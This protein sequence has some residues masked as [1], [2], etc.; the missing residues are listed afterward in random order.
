MAKL[1][2]LAERVGCGDGRALL[3]H[4]LGALLYPPGTPEPVRGGAAWGAASAA[5]RKRTAAGKFS[6]APPGG[7]AAATFA[8]PTAVAV[9]AADISGSP[10]EVAS[11]AG[12][13]PAAASALPDEPKAASAAP[14]PLSSATNNDDTA[15]PATGAGA[16]AL[17]V[18][19]GSAGSDSSSASDPLAVATGADI[20]DA[21]PAQVAAVAAAAAA[22]ATTAASVPFH[23]NA[24]HHAPSASP[25]TR[26][27]Q[28]I[29]AATRP[30]AKALEPPHP[31]GDGGNDRPEL[32]S[33][34]GRRVPCVAPILGASG[35]W[36]SV[37]AS[38]DGSTVIAVGRRSS[39]ID[40][41][42]FTWHAYC[43]STVLLVAQ[44][45][46]PGS[47]SLSSP[48][49]AE[50]RAVGC[51]AQG[52]SSSTVGPADVP[53]CDAIVSS[54]ERVTVP[55]SAWHHTITYRLA[56]RWTAPL[57][58][59]SMPR[60]NAPPAPLGLA[61]ALH[62]AGPVLALSDRHGN[63][64]VWRVPPSD[65]W[66]VFAPYLRQPE[67]M[68]NTRTKLT[69][70]PTG[71]TAGRA[72]AR[73]AP[74][75][76]G[77]DGASTAS[78]AATAT[79]AEAREMDICTSASE[80]AA[81]RPS[82]PAPDAAAECFVDVLGQW[83]GTHAPAG[84]SSGMG[85]GS[86]LRLPPVGLRL[87]GFIPFGCHTP[88]VVPAASVGAPAADA[89]GAAGASG[90]AA[91]TVPP[92][93]SGAT[94]VLVRYCRTGLLADPALRAA[95][96]TRDVLAPAGRSAVGAGE[97]GGV[98]TEASPVHPHLQ[99]DQQQHRPQQ[100]AAAPL[101]WSDGTPVPA[102]VSADPSARMDLVAAA[103]VA[104]GVRSLITITQRDLPVQW[105]PD[106]ASL[107]PDERA[108]TTYAPGAAPRRRGG[109]TAAAGGH[110]TASAAAAP[111]GSRSGDGSGGGGR[112]LSGR[113][114]GGRG[115]SSRGG[116][117]RSRGGARSSTAGSSGANAGSMALYNRL[118]SG[119][120]GKQP[121][122]G[123]AKR[124]TFGAS[125][126][127]RLAA[128]MSSVDGNDEDSLATASATPGAERHHERHPPGG[129]THLE[130]AASAPVGFSAP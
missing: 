63:V 115:A 100:P 36:D 40:T 71:A 73:S 6:K 84:V 32:V 66:T 38:P 120:G 16:L 43:K 119:A 62:P 102:S 96:M 51:S 2:G 15:V 12:S 47:E 10:A 45:C 65:S 80:A 56:K 81:T 30:A 59:V 76:Q 22:Q 61:A 101:L 85:G 97:P 82:A 79:E 17:V 20:S 48:A 83:D 69:V 33:A 91:L 26:V 125:D 99:Q 7:A 110:R 126:T 127:A 35:K 114:R 107:A 117:G 55:G 123:G 50:A 94:S 3:P 116:T 112:A 41:A 124:V 121:G 103:L 75:P 29:P 13:A 8:A 42:V 128:V 92:S 90:T 5:A 130:A 70:A 109:L 18:S 72:G 106:P 31:F 28:P 34:L 27:N 19:T 122:R 111:E 74:A 11:S 88:F 46:R 44:T 57:P 108:G 21:A 78:V 9:P 93:A 113:G 104:E 25:E 86:R 54:G 4:L 77:L 49:G 14:L 23:S 95:V 87:D 89:A 52:S 53:S 98:A 68:E 58:L 64:T 39:D 118:S 60:K 129:P 1:Q 37:V 67:M 24:A 105:L